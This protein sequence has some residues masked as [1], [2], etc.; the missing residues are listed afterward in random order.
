MPVFA[1]LIATFCYGVAICYFKKYLTGAKPLAVAAGSQLVSAVVLLP[2][3]VMYPVTT[4]PSLEAW[5]AVLFL[6]VVCT[7]IA[8]MMYFDLIGKIGASKAIYVGYIVPVFG[9][10]WGWWLLNET[11]SHL[12]LLGAVVILLGVM[13]TSGGF[14][15]AWQWLNSK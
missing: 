4:M 3:V 11:I 12:M 2:L 9:L 7:G 14:D 13:L 15:R 10:I 1:C 8:Y 5:G 6:A